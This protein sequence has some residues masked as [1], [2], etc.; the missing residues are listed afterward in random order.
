MAMWR[1][2]HTV[3]PR[4][5]NL[6]TGALVMAV[7]DCVVQLTVEKAS[8]V[9]PRRTAVCSSFNA[10]ISVPLGMW[11]GML[12]RRWPGVA[13]LNLTRKVIVNQLLSSSLIPTGFLTWTSMGEAVLDG[14]GVNAACLDAVESL[15]K[16][17]AASVIQSFMV[18]GPANTISFLFIPLQLR[19]A[20]M[21]SLGVAW[22][23]YLSYLA[24]GNARC[25]QPTEPAQTL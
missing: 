3:A 10:L 9:E 21:S 24:H 2:L 22:G 8:A 18:W 6:I 15:R 11:Y 13:A 23:G 20:F 7:G 16:N 12:E 1:Q 17:G 14:R 25:T 5:T 4:A 19:I